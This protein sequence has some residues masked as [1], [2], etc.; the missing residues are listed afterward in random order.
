MW[1]LI[2]NQAEESLADVIFFSAIKDNNNE[3]CL[4][5]FF[6]KGW[7]LTLLLNLKLILNLLKKQKFQEHLHNSPPFVQ[8]YESLKFILIPYSKSS[9][10]LCFSSV[11]HH[12]HFSTPYSSSFGINSEA[13]ILKMRLL[14]LTIISYLFNGQYL[15]E[16]RWVSKQQTGLCHLCDPVKEEKTVFMGW[17]HEIQGR[18]T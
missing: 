9:I 14:P 17:Q 8:C 11:P 4:C 7:K 18:I 5:F 10:K 3:T 2:K 16:E 1:L 13:L 15:W 6:K 12:C